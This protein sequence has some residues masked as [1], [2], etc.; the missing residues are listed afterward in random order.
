MIKHILVIDDDNDLRKALCE[1]LMQEED[2]KVQNAQDFKNGWEMLL[3]GNFDAL[4]LDLDLPDGN[5]LDL[6]KRA[7]EHDITIPIIMLTGHTEEQET[8]EAFNLGANDYITKPFRYNELRAR[9]YSHLNQFESSGNS[10]YTVGPWRFRP[11]AKELVSLGDQRK[12]RLTDKECAI[13]RY[14]LRNQGHPV[15]RN[16]M[17]RDIWDYHRDVSTHT[18]E[19]HIYRLRQKIETD[20]NKNLLMTENSGYMLN[21]SDDWNC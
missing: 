20:P 8:V 7:R 18:L 4:I 21:L 16:Q 1:Q 2:F 12:V 14:L 13:I 11:V 19:T 5:G 6:C 3:E 15:T 9:L 17:L 10:T